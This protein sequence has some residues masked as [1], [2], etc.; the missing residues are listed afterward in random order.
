MNRRDKWEVSLVVLALVSV[1]LVAATAK[2]P[3]ETVLADYQVR[4]EAQAPLGW[5]VSR[6]GPGVEQLSKKPG[7]WYLIYTLWRRAD[8]PWCWHNDFVRFNMTTKELVLEGRPFDNTTPGICTR[9]PLTANAA[10]NR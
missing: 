10:A 7:Q 1:L 6:T 5:F 3:S 8:R 9:V 4:A 2:T